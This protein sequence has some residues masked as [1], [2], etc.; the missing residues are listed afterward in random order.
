MRCVPMGTLLA[1]GLVL[2]FVLPGWAA[3][4][5]RE[6]VDSLLARWSLG[7]EA[8]RA[9][10]VAE[11]TVLG[12]EAVAELYRRL[13][14][15]RDFPG[16]DPGVASPAADPARRSDRM[17]TVQ[18]KVAK[19]KGGGWGGPVGGA[20]G[21]RLLETPEELLLA[22]ESDEFTAPR[23]VVYEGQLANVSVLNERRYRRTYDRE[24]RPVE[25]VLELGLV[26]E[27]RAFVEEPGKSVMVDA[28]LVRSELAGEIGTVATPRGRVEV[29]SVVKHEAAFALPLTK[30]KATGLIV[31]GA[32]GSE[33]MVVIVTAEEVRA[34]ED[35]A[36]M[37]IPLEEEKDQE[38]KD[39]KE[40]QG[41][42]G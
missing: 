29:P 39:G 27:L 22:Q 25:G 37:C 18:V 35:G 42:Q 20:R 36:G 33:P 34:E 28:R 13:A 10:V 8:A 11:T 41:E 40:E 26:L 5:L 30:G 3:M 32:P 38:E 9:G 7:D 17:I 12:S 4:D 19:P 1:L 23:I 16:R 21:A 24:G 2:G 6:R 31:P 14:G 15:V